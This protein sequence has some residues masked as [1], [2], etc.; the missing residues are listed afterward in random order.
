MFQGI[1]IGRHEE[2][3]RTML[4]SKN[5][6]TPE[7][8]GCI[9]FVLENAEYLQ[10]IIW[11]PVEDKIDGFTCYRFLTGRIFWYFFLPEAY[12]KDKKNFF[13]APEGTLR[14][15]KAPWAK[16]TIIKR[17]AGTVAERYNSSTNGG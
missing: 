17:I 6:G 10:K 4:F 8:Y 15:V 11:S 12:P 9:M 2:I 14:L 5:P 13:I 7:Q 16:E 1:N 3:I